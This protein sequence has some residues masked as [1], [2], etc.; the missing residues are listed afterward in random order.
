M[1]KDEIQTALRNLPS[2][3]ETVR[4]LSQRWEEQYPRWALVRA[5][6]EEIARIRALILKGEATALQVDPAL[7]ER[8]LQRLLTPSLRPVFNATGVVVHTNL[9]RAPLGQAALDRVVQVAAGYSSLEYSLEQRERGSRHVHVASLLQEIT[10][11][12]DAVVV[13]N[14]AAAV[15]LCLTA[16]ARGREVVVSRGELVEIGGSFRIPDVMA[17]SG[18]LLREVGTT[19]RTHPQDYVA[20]I[21]ENTALLFKAHRSNF[22][23]VGFTAEVGSEE[24]AAIGREQGVLTVYDLGSGTLLDLSQFG[25]PRETSVQ[26]ALEHG[27]DL[28][29]F[30]GDKLLGGPQAGIIVGRGE[31]VEQLRSHPLMRPLRPDKMTLASLAAT[32]ECYRD[33]QAMERLPVVAMLSTPPEVLKRRAQRLRTSLG[34]S[35]SGP[36]TFSLHE[37]SS[38]VG[39]GALPLASP[40]SWAV[41]VEH[42]DL[43]VD[44]VEALLRSADPPVVARIE[45]DRLLLDVRTIT[46][47]QVRTLA[48]TMAAVLKD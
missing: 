1:M 19:N 4:D 15:L 2:V 38:R 41:A 37:V 30:S 47:E 17:A 44:R 21:G 31:C 45:Q 46:D 34:R 33:G 40:R 29:C 32:L 22:A 39:G 3:D 27:V 18:A 43:G 13:N 5:A 11:A 48:R 42:P 28:V 14:N 25:L 6:Q 20:A 26:Q 35:V 9:G 7:L 16:L 23:L 10:G 8:R 36:W 12:E 24:L